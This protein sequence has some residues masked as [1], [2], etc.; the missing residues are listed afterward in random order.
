MA[1]DALNPERRSKADAL[2][3]WLL[4]DARRL[5]DANDILTG[6]CGRLI[7]AGLPLDRA[8]TAI[9]VL[10]SERAGVSRRWERGKGAQEFT[11]DY[12]PQTA[13]VIAASPFKAAHDSGDWLILKLAEM[14]DD[15]F[16]I[17][18]ELKA[19]GYRHYVCAPV[20]FINGMLS[21]FTFAT[22]APDGF[23]AQDIAVLRAIFPALATLMEVLALTRILNEVLRLYVGDEPRKR[24]LAGDV[25]RGQVTRIRSA[26]LFADMRGFTSLSMGL[27][28]EQVTD[29]L[30]RYY[31]CVVPH[32][33]GRGGEVLKF[34][35]DGV[36]AI[37]R[38]GP[39]VAA[40]GPRALAAA[41]ASLAAVDGLNRERGDHPPFDVGIG[42][43]VGE[44]AYGNVGSGQRLDFTVIGRDVNIAS[45]I[46][47]LCGRLEKRLL[48]SAAFS[49]TVAGEAAEDLG[50]FELKGV[51]TAQAVYALEI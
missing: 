36:L 13:E 26:I 40:P 4:G 7:E 5:R 21:G 32:V 11:L 6:M 44:A 43:H 45:R 12:G 8:T 42:L 48:V 19:E 20:A 46:A 47:D 39:E 30:N 18:P 29:L 35:G 3:A 24:I 27:E 14:P 17:I 25:H 16:T 37:F 23:S 1:P 34:I 31:D 38:S 10:H 15:A 51:G 50:A 22:K 28:A 9:E 2:V 33:E 41:R 49:E